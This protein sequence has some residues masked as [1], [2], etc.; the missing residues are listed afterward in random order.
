MKKIAIVIS[1]ILVVNMICFADVDGS[2]KSLLVQLKVGLKDMLA[3]TSEKILDDADTIAENQAYADKKNFPMQADGTISEKIYISYVT[4]SASPY[5]L[6]LKYQ[7]LKWNNHTIPL[8]VTVENVTDENSEDYS[9]DLSEQGVAKNGLR[10]W[11]EK[12]IITAGEDAI[13]NA[14]A[15]GENQYYSATFTLVHNGV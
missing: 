3:F 2:D 11:S 4:N 1:L 5:S 8:T 13:K 12:L 9:I 7:D 15:T 14:P 6:S 10:V